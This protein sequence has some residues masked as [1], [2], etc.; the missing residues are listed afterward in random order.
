MASIT[1]PLTI[2][3]LIALCFSVT[4]YYVGKTDTSCVTSPN[5]TITLHSNESCTAANGCIDYQTYFYVQ[6]SLLALFLIL[7]A[8]QCAISGVCFKGATVAVLI[9][10]MLWSIISAFLYFRRPVSECTTHTKAFI[11]ISTVC[12]MFIMP[13]IVLLSYAFCGLT[14][15]KN[16]NRRDQDEFA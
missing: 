3:A 6:A 9:V 11:I 15:R 10:S 1:I 8:L 13:A 7:Y 12:T 16:K 14:C 2:C 4:N 5:I